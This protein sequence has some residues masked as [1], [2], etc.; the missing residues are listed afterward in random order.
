MTNYYKLTL[1]GVKGQ[2]YASY[3]RGL[4]LQ[5]INELA[6]DYD[7]DTTTEP[8]MIPVYWP[9]RVYSVFAFEELK[10]KSVSAKCA[11][12]V[13][14]YKEHRSVVYTPSKIERANLR[15][16]TVSPELLTVYLTA[17]DYPLA[18]PK[19]ITDYIRNYNAVRDLAVNGKPVKAGFPD[20]Y[21]REYERTLGDNPAKL[22][23]YWAHLRTLGWAKIDGVWQVKRMHLKSHHED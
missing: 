8:P 23:L 9:D 16:V 19:S 22:Q 11:L 18:G 6:M 21:D 15:H 12:F 7:K 1:K 4:L 5:C 20:V 17:K 10:P 13:L 2:A 3:A 14:M